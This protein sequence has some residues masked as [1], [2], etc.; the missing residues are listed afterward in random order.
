MAG[1]GA[2]ALASAALVPNAR[3]E[4]NTSVSVG[5]GHYA[6]QSAIAAGVNYYVSN[7]VLLN[8]KVALTSAGPAKGG[9]SV[10]AT[11]GF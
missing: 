4:G 1:V 3:A 8:A 6:G 5:A 2:M 7:Q 10:G 9:V 11:F